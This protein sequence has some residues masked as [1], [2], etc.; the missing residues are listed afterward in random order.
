MQPL[1]IRKRL[2]TQ[3]LYLSGGA[4]MYSDYLLTLDVETY[5]ME[6]LLHFV[7]FDW[8]I[9]ENQYSTLAEV[10]REVLVRQSTFCLQLKR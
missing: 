3:S 1:Q 8:I 6:R 5:I 9:A 10:I 4:D 2:S 7:V